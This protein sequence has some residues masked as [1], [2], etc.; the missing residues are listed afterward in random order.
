MLE[1][2]PPITTASNRIVSTFLISFISH[3]P[4]QFGH[5][6]PVRG[7][8][9]LVLEF[10]LRAAGLRLEHILDERGLFFVFVAGR[11]K[12]LRSCL[13]SGPR[14]LQKQ[15]SLLPLAVPGPDFNRDLRL[16]L[17]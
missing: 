12:L 14:G 1:W 17:A 7:K 5:R 15:D 3:C 13:V 11:P 2:Q 6:T 9:L 10:R 8:R 4:A 16:C